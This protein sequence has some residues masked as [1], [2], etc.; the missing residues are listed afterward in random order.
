MYKVDKDKFIKK[1]K[2]KLK[3]KKQKE[4]IDY[5]C[6]R[7]LEPSEKEIYEELE[8]FDSFKYN[9]YRLK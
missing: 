5:S 4:T 1:L 9:N 2:K 8:Y 7:L 3:E 6:F